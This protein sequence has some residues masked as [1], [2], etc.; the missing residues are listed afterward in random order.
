MNEW[1]DTKAIPPC[2]IEGFNVPDTFDYDLESY[3]AAPEEW[4]EFMVEQIVKIV[5]HKRT[6]DIDKFISAVQNQIFNL[7]INIYKDLNSDELREKTD[8][9]NKN[10]K[11]Q[12]L[13]K[14]TALEEVGKRRLRTT[15]EYLKLE[16]E[17][18]DIDTT[19][20]Q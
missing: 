8:E 19:T 12:V 13:D 10:L 4:K 14:I 15:G 3:V 17:D 9:L 5:K 6:V 18:L 20:N 11:K 7:V 1:I 16:I 2:D